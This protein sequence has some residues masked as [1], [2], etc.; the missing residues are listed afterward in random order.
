MNI[1]LIIGLLLLLFL[2]PGLNSCKSHSG[3]EPEPVP[4]PEEEVTNLRKR[5]SL[6]L[7]ALYKATDGEYW[8]SFFGNE[9]WE[10]LSQP[11]TNSANWHGVTTKKVDGE[12]RVTEIRL[13]GYFKSG[14]EIPEEIGNLTALEALD[15]SFNGL[16]GLIPE[17]FA[18]LTKLQELRLNDNNFDRQPLEFLKEM[19]G[20]KSLSLE[21]NH[22]L[23]SLPSEI[24]N[25]SDLY[26]LDI[27]QN[28]FT[29]LPA[30]IGKLKNLCYLYASNNQLTTFPA[31]SAG[32][33]AL[34]YLFIN[35]N[36]LTTFPSCILQMKKMIYLNIKNNMIS[37]LQPEE[38]Q[39]QLPELRYFD[40]E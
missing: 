4:S 34:T 32:L 8:E 19:T 7:V 38:I 5:D 35:S 9:I 6:A 31:E 14:G 36:Q 20:M 27:S 28:Q 17:S 18:K 30:S 39:N 33:S 15:L 11:I 21:N 29:E 25:M 26:Y 12:I 3:D 1:K 24:G 16:E 22:N 10:S 2:Q 13:P 37:D 40:Y 23:H